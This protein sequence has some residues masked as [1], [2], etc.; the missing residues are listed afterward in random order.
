[1]PDYGVI[2]SLPYLD[3]VV[4]ETLRLHAPL[5][6]IIRSCTKDYV[7]QGHAIHWKKHNIREFSGIFNNFFGNFLFADL[8]LPGNGFSFSQITLNLL[9]W[10]FSK[11][12]KI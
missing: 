3:Q 10:L 1:M 5:G 8:K 6:T 7:L 11:P 4:Q 9:L 12:E 2:Q